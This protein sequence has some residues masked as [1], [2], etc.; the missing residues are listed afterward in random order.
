MEALRIFEAVDHSCCVLEGG[1]WSACFWVGPGV[2]DENEKR[3]RASSLFVQLLTHALQPPPTAT[4]PSATCMRIHSGSMRGMDPSLIAGTAGS[5]QTHPGKVAARLCVQGSYKT[6]V[7]YARIYATCDKVY[8]GGDEVGCYAVGWESAP[9]L[10]SVAHASS[11]RCWRCLAVGS[12]HVTA[13][14]AL[15]EPL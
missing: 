5:R 6:V 11:A 8:V 15:A 14:L 3:E 2:D 12:S 7:G 4:Y 9:E 10:D 1:G 13:R